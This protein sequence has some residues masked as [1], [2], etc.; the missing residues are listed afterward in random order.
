MIE[1]VES[2]IKKLIMFLLVKERGRGNT[3]E[4]VRRRVRNDI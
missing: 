4:G 1:V 2:Y 3:V